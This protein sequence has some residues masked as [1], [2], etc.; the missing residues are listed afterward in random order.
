[1]QQALDVVRI[2]GNAAVHPGDLRVDDDEPLARTMF[3]LVNLIAEDLL[4]KPKQVQAL[5]NGMPQGPRDAVARRDASKGSGSV[6]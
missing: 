6:P 3:G 2:V 1:V 5:F 4:T